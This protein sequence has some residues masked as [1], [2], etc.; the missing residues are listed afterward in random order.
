MKYKVYDN[1]LE[2]DFLEKFTEE[3]TSDR[4]PWFSRKYDVPPIK[5]VTNNKNGYFNHTFYNQDQ[6]K[7]PIYDWY[8]KDILKKMNASTPIN[9]TAN[10][11][12]RDIDTVESAYHTDDS[13][14]NSKTAI[15]Y[16]T[17][18]NAKTVLK[19]DDKEIPV[20]SKKNR[21][22]IF[23][24]DIQHKLVYQTDIHKRYIVNFNYYE[25]L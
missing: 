21:I 16:L 9:V 18:C 14:T 22:L 15:L 5:G 7:S 25:R 12:L 2:K 23:N 1:F 10:L 13:L 8:I 6:P 20:E 11:T 3:I 19:I 4:I 24:T 17:S